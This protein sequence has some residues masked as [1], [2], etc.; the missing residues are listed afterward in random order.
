MIRNAKQ[1][2]KRRPL[3]SS[4]L[5]EAA[6]G[7]MHSPGFLDALLIWTNWN[8]CAPNGQRVMWNL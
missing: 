2:A 3:I 1:F 5:M 6:S 4:S 7:L 8:H